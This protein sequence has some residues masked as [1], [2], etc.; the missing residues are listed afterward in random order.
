MEGEGTKLWSLVEKNTHVTATAR[1]MEQMTPNKDEY[2]RVLAF[3]GM[4]IGKRTKREKEKADIYYPFL[5]L[6]NL[7]LPSHSLSYDS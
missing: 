1:Y 6:P 3:L 5:L 7:P 4:D 2:L